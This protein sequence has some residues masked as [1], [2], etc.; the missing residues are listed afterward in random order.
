MT[1]T[2]DHCPCSRQTDPVLRERM[3]IAQSIADA[4]ARL[5]GIVP[6]RVLSELWSMAEC[7]ACYGEARVPSRESLRY[8]RRAA[9]GV[10]AWL[11]GV[12]L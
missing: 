3:H 5:E 10:G 12:R 1:C 11:S 7:V 9:L 8:D 4:R 2:K 6:A